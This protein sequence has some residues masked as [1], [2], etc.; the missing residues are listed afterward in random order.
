MTTY[1]LLDQGSQVSLIHHSL[2]AQLNLKGPK[3]RTLTGTFHGSDPIIVT[4]RV[5][6][7]LLLTDGISSFRVNQA[8]AVPNLNISRPAIDWSMAARTDGRRRGMIVRTR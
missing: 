3:R 2:A 5:N 1:A 8:E 4:R 6:F 7:E